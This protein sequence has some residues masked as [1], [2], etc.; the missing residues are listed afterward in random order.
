MADRRTFNVVVLGLGFLFI[1][2]A[3]TTCGNIEVSL[4]SVIFPHQFKTTFLQ[5]LIS[6]RKCFV[7]AEVRVL[8]PELLSDLTG[9]HSAQLIVF[10]QVN[11]EPVLTYVVLFSHYLFSKMSFHA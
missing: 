6:F 3:F 4:V 9:V 8:F 2:T 10:A 7:A 5:R 11:D 1:F